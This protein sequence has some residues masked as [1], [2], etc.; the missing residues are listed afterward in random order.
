MWRGTIHLASEPVNLALSGG[1]RQ[2]DNAALA[3]AC[4]IP[5]LLDEWRVSIKQEL[6][7]HYEIRLEDYGRRDPRRRTPLP[8]TIESRDLWKHVRLLFIAISPRDDRMTTELGYKAGWDPTHIL[9]ARF[10][11]REFVE[12]DDNAISP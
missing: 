1:P 3:A 4:A 5:E 7:Q 8:I 9:G 6:L 2:P 12:L 10:V 11:G